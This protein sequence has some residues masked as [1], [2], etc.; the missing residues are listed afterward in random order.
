MDSWFL[1]EMPDGCIYTFPSGSNTDPQY[2]YVARLNPMKGAIELFGPGSPD[3][4]N[5]SYCWG[6]D[7]TGGLY[8]VAADDQYLYSTLGGMPYLLN[9]YHFETGE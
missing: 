6:P 2:A 8:H 1:A 9:A 7:A 4:W 5:Y 3:S